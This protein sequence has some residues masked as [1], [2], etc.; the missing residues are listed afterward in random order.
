MLQGI[1][2]LVRGVVAGELP[3]DNL[4]KAV[5]KSLGSL[6]DQIKVVDKKK[7]EVCGLIDK[8]LL[9]RGPGPWGV[10]PKD[11]KVEDIKDIGDSWELEEL[12]E[13]LQKHFNVL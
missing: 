10:W 3:S 5:D 6:R 1:S 7:E 12:L 2:G 8:K 4:W 11:I 13:K 9:D